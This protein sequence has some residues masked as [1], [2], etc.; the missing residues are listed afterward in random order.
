[1]DDQPFLSCFWG[2]REVSLIHILSFYRQKR[3]FTN[4]PNSSCYTFSKRSKK[5][6]GSW[7]K[8]VNLISLS[9]KSAYHLFLHTSQLQCLP[10]ILSFIGGKGIQAS[11]A[12]LGRSRYLHYGVGTICSRL[13]NLVFSLS[14]AETVLSL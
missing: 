9:A 14:R 10:I 3:S 7:E 12:A 8:P 6:K 4:H 11:Q 1:M 2:L 5:R 13:H